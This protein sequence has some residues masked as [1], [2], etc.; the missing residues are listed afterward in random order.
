MEENTTDTR[1]GYG[2]VGG[3]NLL[4]TLTDACTQGWTH[5]RRLI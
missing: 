4:E 3:I 5:A 2:V 1:E